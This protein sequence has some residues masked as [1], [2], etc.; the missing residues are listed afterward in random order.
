MKRITLDEKAIHRGNLIL[1]NSGHPFEI[2]AKPW[3]LV[4]ANEACEEIL[5]DRHAASLLEK[6]ME[7]IAGWEEIVPVS[8]WRSREEQREIY[9]GS[10]EKEG[11]DFTKKYVA[12]PGHSEHETGLAIDLALK[13]EA[14]DFIRPH[15]PYH[16]ICRKFREKAGKFGFVERYQKGKENLT[17]IGQEPW[18]FRYVGWPHAEI[19]ENHSLA[20]EEYLEF[21]KGYPH[22]NWHYR[23]LI[24][25]HMAV[26]VSYLKGEEKGSVALELPEDLPYTI[27]GNNIDGYIVTEWRGNYEP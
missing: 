19:M 12:L 5:L 8:G 27:S 14:I 20:L 26:E 18:H 1:V 16:G 6:L 22:G 24:D 2:S 13:D 21:I 11:L 9:A 4:P 3:A 17:G 15:F 7:S 25:R 10:L 23:H